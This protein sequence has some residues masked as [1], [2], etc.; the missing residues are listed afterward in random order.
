MDKIEGDLFIEIT[1]VLLGIFLSD[2]GTNEDLSEAFARGGIGRVARESNA[3]GRGGV[4]E[5]LLVELG[6]FLFPYKMNAKHGALKIVLMEEEVS[7]F[8]D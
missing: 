4:V 6:D 7:D 8:V 3:I 2:E 5:E 1:P